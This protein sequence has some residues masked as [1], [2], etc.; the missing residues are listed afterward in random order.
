MKKRTSS[1]KIATIFVSLFMLAAVI[2]ASIHLLALH[3]RQIPPLLQAPQWETAVRNAK[4]K[5]EAQL[6]YDE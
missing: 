5:Y 4:T 6:S 2:F 1:K 3:T